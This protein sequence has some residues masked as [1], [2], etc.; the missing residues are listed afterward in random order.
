MR[1]KREELKK[2]IGSNE[3]EVELCNK[4]RTSSDMQTAF[5]M[6]RINLKKPK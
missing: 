4:F 3:M 6:E 5:A 2:I 1:E